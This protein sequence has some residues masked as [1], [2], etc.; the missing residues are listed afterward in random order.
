MSRLFFT[1]RGNVLLHNNEEITRWR[2]A[3]KQ[4]TLP[5]E[6]ARGPAELWLM[7]GCYPDNA[8]PL[9]VEINGRHTAEIAPTGEK[10]P[11]YWTW[12]PVSVPAG[13]LREGANEVLLRSDN[14]TMNGWMLAI[15][16]T[17]ASSRSY[18]SND[19][20]QT[21]RNKRLGAHNA[22]R[23]EYVIRLRANGES[24]REHRP[25]RVVLENPEHPRVR[26]LREIVPAS[27]REESD[28]WQQVLALRAWVA[29]QWTHDGSGPAYAPWDPWTV[30]DW[31]QR[32]G[33]HGRKGKVTFCVHFSTTFVALVTALGHKA[34]CLAITRDVAGPAGHFV[35]E[36]FDQRHGK[37]V[38][39]D[40][41]CDGHYELDGVP[42][43]GPDIMERARRGEDC[44]PLS[45][46]GEG[47]VNAA[48]HVRSAWE[49][50]FATGYSYLNM[51]VWAHN[52]YVS[53]PTSA[54]PNHGSV[55]YCETDF[56]WYT[57][58]EESRRAV[59]M[60]PYRVAS[61]GWFDRAPKGTGRRVAAAQAAG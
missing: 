28:P 22:L 29:Q 1:E 2:W 42:L 13:V 61:R 51:A 8:A 34:R 43:A 37:W 56:V 31:S 12:C 41:N 16:N 27:V 30:L 6:A 19:R 47:M 40:A 7:L 15:D 23:G 18:V 4:F 38:L 55:K 26:E 46:T 57:P 32:N 11:D 24:L 35:C 54:P 3:K 21:W 14:P 17:A 33:G 53:D 48:P 36:V 25:P 50:S 20:G 39:H 59:A 45:H 49:R 5:A 10:V 60:F 52:N 58:S 9:T 44:T